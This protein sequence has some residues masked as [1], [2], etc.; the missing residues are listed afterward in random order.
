M[1]KETAPDGAFG[2]T[3]QSA[4]LFT[5]SSLSG[6]PALCFS[7]YVQDFSLCTLTG[8]DYNPPSA[9]KATVELSLTAP[10]QRLKVNGGTCFFLVC[11]ELSK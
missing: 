9:L 8:F 4:V 2:F 10:G 1:G 5:L 3:T 11:S 7:G 6:L